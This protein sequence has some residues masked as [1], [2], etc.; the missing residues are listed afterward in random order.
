LEKNEMT[1]LFLAM[2]AEFCNNTGAARNQ[3]RAVAAA[4]KDTRAPPDFV[5][6]LRKSWINTKRRCDTFCTSIV[7]FFLALP[8]GGCLLRT[9]SG[10]LLY[11]IQLPSANALL[12]TATANS[13][14]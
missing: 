3:E 4:E 9:T 1:Y 6:T 10:E 7:S 2:N 8:M 13:T 12:I 11:R 5:E 14:L